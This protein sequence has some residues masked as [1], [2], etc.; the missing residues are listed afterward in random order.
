MVKDLFHGIG[1][2]AKTFTHGLSHPMHGAA[3]DALSKAFKD[4]KT[5]RVPDAD[6]LFGRLEAFMKDVRF[7]KASCSAC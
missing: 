1:D 7:S 2:Y 4:E 6:A 5:G 3:M